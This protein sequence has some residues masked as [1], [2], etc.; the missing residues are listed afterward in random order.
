MTSFVSKASALQLWNPRRAWAMKGNNIELNKS[1][2]EEP[3][4][5][6]HAVKGYIF[7]MKVSSATT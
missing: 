2:K 6:M 5:L 7:T 4:V 3:F 1:N